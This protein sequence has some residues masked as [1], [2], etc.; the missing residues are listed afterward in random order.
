MGGSSILDMREALGKR[1][2]LLA[3]L[4]FLLLVFPGALYRAVDRDEPKY[5]ESARQMILSGDYIT[6][7]FNCKKRFDKPILTYWLVVVGYKLFGVSAAAGRVVVSLF[8]ALTV[9]M[10]YIWLLPHLGEEVAFWAGLTLMVLVD[11][12]AMSGVAMPDV[13][14]TFFVSAAAVSFYQERFVLFSLFCALAVL[15]KGPVGVVLPALFA[16]YR[17]SS[18]RR[19]PWLTAAF[20]FAAFSAPWYAAA[21]LK[22][23][24]H[25]FREFFLFHNIN[26]FLSKVPGHSTQWWYYLANYPWMFL[27]V[28]PLLPFAIPWAFKRKGVLGYSAFWFL[29]VFAFFQIAHTKLVHYLL[30]AFPA[31]AVVVSARFC[32]Y[33]AY[34]RVVAGFF[35]LLLVARWL[36]VP[37]LDAKR[38]GPFVARRIGALVREGTYRS[39]YF[40]RC[41]LPSMV[42]YSGVCIKK[43][44]SG[45]LGRI[46]KRDSLVIMKAKELPSL[47]IPHR[48]LFT[49]RPLLLGHKLA[50]IT[51]D[52]S[53]KGGKP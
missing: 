40:Y 51:A 45:E 21:V 4:S 23:G 38:E 47:R 42:F 26:R 41:F 13:V 18:F 39:A 3:L 44:R 34:R 29:V 27:P 25:F 37:A 49:F 7:R 6:P 9:L 33:R 11:F 43:A 52:A 36:L 28:S 22:N 46:L 50:I 14:L 31:A 5:L 24:S 48:V 2:A 32:R 8:G 53:E 12:T 30:P 35:V 1:F 17:V 20:V 19:F 10:L 16:L 15:T